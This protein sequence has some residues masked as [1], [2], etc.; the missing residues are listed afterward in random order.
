MQGAMSFDRFADSFTALGLVERIAAVGLL[1]T[2]AELLARPRTLAQD[3]LLS[4]QVARLRSPHLVVGRK[5]PM[6]DVLLAPPG[7]YAL[8]TT[9]A[10]GAGLVLIAPTA[11]GPS[12]LALAV[13][14]ATSLL[15]MLR[16]SYGNDGGDQMLML[17]IVSSTVARG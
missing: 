6:L 15:L 10:V 16:T 9:R 14:A 5:A 3:G 12:M 8:I 2:S 17:V 1:L 13:C 11:S 7:V 4:W